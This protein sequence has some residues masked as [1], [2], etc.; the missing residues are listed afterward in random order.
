MGRPPCCDGNGLKKGPWT[1]EEDQKLTDYIDKQGRGSWRQLP[2]L[3]GIFNTRLPLCLNALAIVHPKC[4]WFH[5]S[6]RTEQ[7]RKELQAEMDQLPEARYQ[8]RKVQL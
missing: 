2:K 7:V 8:E 5:A 1:T 6:R 3:A 4:I